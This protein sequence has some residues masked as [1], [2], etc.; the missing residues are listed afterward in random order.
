LGKFRNL[1]AIV[2]NPICREAF[3]DKPEL[4]HAGDPE[5]L[6]SHGGHPALAWIGEL[7]E[8]AQGAGAPSADLEPLQS[9]AETVQLGVDV[10]TI[11]SEGVADLTAKLKKG[12]ALAQRRL[13]RVQ[14]LANTIDQRA[15]AAEVEGAGGSAVAIAEAIVG[16]ERFAV[17]AAPS[18]I[19]ASLLDEELGAGGQ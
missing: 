4:T 14:R 15:C 1:L 3:G 5:R 9:K 6:D 8:R 11:E 19:D 16:A 13:E 12:A 7:S 18:G 2:A 17:A 10:A